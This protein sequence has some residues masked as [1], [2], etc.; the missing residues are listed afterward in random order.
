M[1]MQSEAEQQKKMQKRMESFN[2]AWLVCLIKRNPNLLISRPHIFF[3]NLHFSSELM[4]F[5]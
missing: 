2:T 4:R 1:W 5:C 3:P